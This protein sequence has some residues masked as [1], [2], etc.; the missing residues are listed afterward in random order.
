MQDASSCLRRFLGRG[1]YKHMSADLGKDFLNATT[2]ADAAQRELAIERV[3]PGACIANPLRFALIDSGASSHLIGRSL[4]T[5]AERDTIYK[6][7]LST[8]NLVEGRMTLDAARQ[9]TSGDGR[10]GMSSLALLMMLSATF[11]VML[12]PRRC[13][14]PLNLFC[15]RLCFRPQVA[16]WKHSGGPCL[17]Q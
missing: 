10:L 7:S 12:L 2:L 17:R 11:L 16:C 6:V 5:D 13:T 15:L 14:M 1:R 8:Y 3:S 9:A 4:L